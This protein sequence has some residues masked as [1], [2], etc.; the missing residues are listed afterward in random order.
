MV[1]LLVVAAV[2]V[3]HSSSLEDPVS[4]RAP[5]LATWRET[6]IWD[7]TWKLQHVVVIKLW[8]HPCGD[9]ENGRDG[10]SP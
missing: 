2:S 7:V 8:R 5:G 4:I 1:T 3:S 9:F 10:R 6:S